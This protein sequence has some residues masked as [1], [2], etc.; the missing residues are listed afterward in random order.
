MKKEM[1]LLSG[2]ALAFAA[3][4]AMATGGFV[5][6][7]IGKAD[8]DVDVD[9]L[10]DGSDDDTSFSIRGGY[11]F[12][13]NFAV[14]GFYSSFYDKS[15]SFDD[16]AG[17]TVD[18]DLKLTGLGV[19]I[20]GKTDIGNDQ[21]GFFAMGRAGLMR[22]RI[23]ASATGFGSEHDTSTKPYFGVGVGYDF[24]PK[25]GVS[26]NWDQQKGSSE[27][28]DITARTIALGVEARF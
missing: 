19:G 9:G 3:S 23:D 27:G 16:G 8:V 6:G 1:M 28:V 15:E 11:F 7:E 17:G 13:N 14:E 4:P 25:F 2:L 20:V 18:A 21:T 24:S 26:L 22:G 12:N 10:G 5:R